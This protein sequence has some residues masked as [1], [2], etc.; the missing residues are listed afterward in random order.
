MKQFLLSGALMLVMGAVHAQYAFVEQRLLNRLEVAADAEMIPVMLLLDDRVDVA[1]LKAKMK[2]ES[3][4]VSR[5]SR[6]VMRALKEKAAESQTPLVKFVT[7]SGLPF[8]NLQQFWISNCISFSANAELIEALTFRPEV[9]YIDLNPAEYGLITPEKGNASAPKSEGGIEPGLAVINAPEMW[10]LGYT[11]NGRIALTFDTGV[12]PEHP[13]FGDRFLPNRMPLESTWFGY[14]SPLPTDKSSSHGTHVSGIILGLDTATADTIGVAPQAYFIATDPI[15]SNIAFVKP[16]SD[17]MLGFEWALNPDGDEET[18][19]DIPDVIN[20]SWGRPNDIE[21]QDWGACSQFV[22]PV[23]AAVEAAGIANVFSA[24]NNGPDD[25]TIGIPNNI[26]MG[27]VNTFSVGA[28]NGI[29]SGPWNVASFS[30]RGPS[31]CDADGSLLIKPE[32]SAPGVNV[33]SSVA[34]GQYDLFSGTS[35]ASPHVS[36]AVL[37]LKEA[38]PYLTGE[39]ILTALYFSAVDQGNPGEDNTYGMGVIDVK[40]AFDLLSTENV[41]VPPASPDIDV[42]LVAILTPESGFVC[43]SENNSTTVDA[44]FSIQNNGLDAVSGLGFI[45]SV[46]GGEEMT[47]SSAELTILPGA[48]SSLFL[49][50][51]QVSGSG[52]KELHIRIVPLAGEYDVLNNNGVVR[53]TQLPEQ[54]EELFET[55]SEGI[56]PEKWLVVNPD[57]EVGWDTTYTVQSANSSEASGIAAWMN[58]PGY[59]NI[60]S[61]KDWLVS[62]VVGMSWIDVSSFDLTFD[63]FYRRRNNSSSTFQYDTLTVYKV[64]CN[65]NIQEIIFQKGGESLWTNPNSQVNAFPETAADWMSYNA[66]IESEPFYIIFETTNRRGNNILL[67]NIQI[68]IGVSTMNYPGPSL[69]LLPNPARD[70]IRIKWSGNSVSATISIFDVRGKVVSRKGVVG[71]ESSIDITSLAKGVYIVQ[72]EFAK[73]ET[74]ISKLVVQ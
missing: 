5:H 23:M 7:E 25:Q 68:T 55:F 60:A 57:S 62:P 32:V 36:G 33:R 61:Q 64:G 13:T 66:Q 9:A 35:M 31:V 1:A 42:E 22:I 11:G 28:V 45:Y 20:N 54:N 40:A 39:D 15:V 51:F 41:P 44:S 43:P 10:A 37:L 19:S 73:G 50:S 58:H 71:Q 16:L 12:W 18:S 34:N 24:G 30:S 52:F 59:N 70:A 4:P 49:P 63:Y 38:F 8:E 14:D 29:G 48:S 53:W 72:A 3:I 2:I 47:Y 69:T 26:N 56:D 21:D 74:S 67:D 6:V 27:L 46:N 65:S 17:L